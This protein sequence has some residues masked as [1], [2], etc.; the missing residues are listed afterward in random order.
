M[1]WRS[2]A[3]CGG[4]PSFRCTPLDYHGSGV[5]PCPNILSLFTLLLFPLL[6][7]SLSVQLSRALL[8]DRRT[9]FREE[10]ENETGEKRKTCEAAA[11]G[12]HLDVLIYAHEKGGEYAL[13]NG[14]CYAAAKQCYLAV[15]KYL[16]ENQP[17]LCSWDEHTCMYAAKGGHLEVLKYARDNGCPEASFDD[18]FDDFSG[19][20]SSDF[21]S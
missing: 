11:Q 20:D 21:E 12:G 7:S 16:H 10:R 2:H 19:S 15:L 6:S 14:A 8:R 5:T 4:R 17:S 1:A 9:D 13:K 3:G 18:D